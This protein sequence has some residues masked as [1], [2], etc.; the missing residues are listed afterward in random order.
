MVRGGQK[1]YQVQKCLRSWER[2]KKRGY[3][4]IE[5]NEFNCNLDE[6]P[7]LRKMYAEKKWAFVSDYI[8]LKI[9]QEY[10]GIYLDTDVYVYKDFDRYLQCDSFWGLE[11]DFAIGTA[12]IG[13]KKGCQLLSALLGVYDGLCEDIIN[14]GLITDFFLDKI[15]GFKVNGKTQRL[16][17]RN[18]SSIEEIWLYNK[19][20]FNRLAQFIYVSAAGERTIM[21]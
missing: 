17:Y 15:T 5:W 8:R 12:V 13:A 20:V 1:S 4:I 18:N 3:K 10:G 21:P 19:T 7:Y 9:L 11:Y 16:E 14:N 2:L 6:N